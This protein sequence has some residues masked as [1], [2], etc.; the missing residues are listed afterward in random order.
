[1]EYS[2]RDCIDDCIDEINEIKMDYLRDDYVQNNI[3]YALNIHWYYHHYKNIYS[4]HQLKNDLSSIWEEENYWRFRKEL[5]EMKE[6]DITKYINIDCRLINSVLKKI[7][8][9]IFSKQ[10]GGGAEEIN[11][12][13]EMIKD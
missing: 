2:E 6:S 13:T 7:N 8:I 4:V 5:K 1:M 9:D 11:E 12:I 10:Q 3:D